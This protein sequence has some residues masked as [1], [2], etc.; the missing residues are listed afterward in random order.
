MDT[1][2][3]QNLGQLYITEGASWLEAAL[4]SASYSE[5]IAIIIEKLTSRMKR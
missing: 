4:L 1:T 3:Y 2:H 5:R